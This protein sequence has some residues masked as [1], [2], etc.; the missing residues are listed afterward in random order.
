MLDL[1]HL[2]FETDNGAHFVVLL[3]KDYV[4]KVPYKELFRSKDKVSEIVE[5]QNA[6]S[7]LS[8]SIPPAKQVGWAIVSPRIKGVRVDKLNPEKQK[9]LKQ[10][11]KQISSDM[12]KEGYIIG[13][14]KSANMIYNEKKDELTLIDFSLAG[15]ISP[16]RRKR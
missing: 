5:Y 9:E 15:K 10:R 1:N 6:M 4:I 7:K 8:K 13:D 16:Q 14:L 11:A 2:P 12:K 3:F